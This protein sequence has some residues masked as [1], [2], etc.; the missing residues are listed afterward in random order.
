MI[1]RIAAVALAGAMAVQAL[2]VP[3]TAQANTASAVCALSADALSVYRYDGASW[4]RIGGQFTRL[5]SGGFGLFATTSF[6]NLVRYSGTPFSWQNIGGPRGTWAVTDDAIYALPSD[7]SGVWKWTGSGTTWTQ[8]GGPA[9]RLYGGGYGLFATIPDGTGISQYL[10]TPF[11]WRFLGRANHEH[12]S[13]ITYAVTSQNLFALDAV[14][15]PYRWNAAMG[16]FDP[17]IPADGGIRVSLDSLFGG[18]FAMGLDQE[19][20][21]ATTHGSI[22]MIRP[23]SPFPITDANMDVAIP[24]SSVFISSPQRDSVWKYDGG[25]SWSKVGAVATRQLVPCL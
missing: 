8:V 17:E 14:H 12:D 19:R 15:E 23:D 11:N 16:V 22:I 9:A 1:K 13:D 25:L 7:H 18:A 4:V 21:L 5:Y 24:P 3:G 20:R 2:A 6:G 10:G